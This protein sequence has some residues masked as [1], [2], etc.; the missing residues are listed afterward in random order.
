MQLWTSPATI[1]TMECIHVPDVLVLSGLPLEKPH[2]DS[3]KWNCYLELRAVRDG[4][5]LGEAGGWNSL[6]WAAGLVLAGSAH[7]PN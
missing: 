2:L 7:C 1:I 3:E 5:P 4:K 6:Q